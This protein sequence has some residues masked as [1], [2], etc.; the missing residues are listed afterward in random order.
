[1]GKPIGKLKK[2]N[3]FPLTMSSFQ[4]KKYIEAYNEDTIEKGVYINSRQASLF[5]FPDGSYGS[6]GFNKYIINF[7]YTITS[8]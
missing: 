6:K 3:V 5:V 2:F 7:Y 4:T 1:M 8:V